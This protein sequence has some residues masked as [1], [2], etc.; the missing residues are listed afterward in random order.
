MAEEKENKALV[1]RHSKRTVSGLD[2]GDV[3]SCDFDMDEPMQSAVSSKVN[4]SACKKI[5][6]EC[7]EYCKNECIQ[8]RQSFAESSDVFLFKKCSIMQLILPY[9]T[10][11]KMSVNFYSRTPSCC[12]ECT[13]RTGSLEQWIFQHGCK[14]KPDLEDF[15]IHEIEGRLSVLED[16]FQNNVLG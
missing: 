9:A 8:F 10:R 7:F 13:S 3:S 14:T 4:N 6:A 15:M 5:K 12:S 16:L 11:L 1:C 2:G